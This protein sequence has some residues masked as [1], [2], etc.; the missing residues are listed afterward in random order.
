M[1]NKAPG[2][3]KLLAHSRNSTNIPGV[4][5]IRTASSMFMTREE[6]ESLGWA[7][8]FRSLGKEARREKDKFARQDT[9]LEKFRG[10]YF[11]ARERLAATISKNKAMMELRHELQQSRRDGDEPEAQTPNSAEGKPPVG[12][13][14]FNHV[15]LRY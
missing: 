2:Y 7:M 14:S 9:V 5:D 4:R 3:I 6:R 10:N 15:E 8:D 11:K 13:N 12:E 1:K